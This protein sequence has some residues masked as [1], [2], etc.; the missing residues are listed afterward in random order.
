[1][2]GKKTIKFIFENENLFV[3]YTRST[4]GKFVSLGKD[5]YLRNSKLLNNKILIKSV[6][7]DQSMKKIKPKSFAS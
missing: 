7:I 6:Y 4:K 3:K 5:G 1:M 2:P